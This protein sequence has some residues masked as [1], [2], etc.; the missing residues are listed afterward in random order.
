MPAD[1]R[2]DLIR[3]L[4][5]ETHNGVGAPQN[6]E[7]DR[8]EKKWIEKLIWKLYRVE[9]NKGSEEYCEKG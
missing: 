6:V 5:S 2:W 4:K 9:E 8:T 1:R 3:R 7:E